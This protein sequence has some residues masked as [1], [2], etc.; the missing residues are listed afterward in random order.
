VLKS[1]WVIPE[2]LLEAGYEF[3]FGQIEDAVRDIVASRR[4]RSPS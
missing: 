2:R 3:R 1:R 4:S